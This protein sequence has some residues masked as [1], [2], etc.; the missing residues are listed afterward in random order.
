M[1][2]ALTAGSQCP[3]DILGLDSND[4]LLVR[5]ESEARSHKI[6]RG[7]ADVL[8]A[9]LSCEDCLVR[10]ATRFKILIVELNR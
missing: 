10:R 2:G 7:S 8:G 6:F 1:R 9:A 5:P 4:W 3:V